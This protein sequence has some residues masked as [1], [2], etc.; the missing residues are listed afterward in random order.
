MELYYRY[1]G[2]N[3]NKLLLGIS[4]FLVVSV[5]YYI[6]DTFDSSQVGEEFHSFIWTTSKWDYEKQSPGDNFHVIIKFDESTVEI[7]NQ[8]AGQEMTAEFYPL[9]LD[10]IESFEK[11]LKKVMK[12]YEIGISIPP[13]TEC[14]IIEGFVEDTKRCLPAVENYEEYQFSIHYKVYQ[15][16]QHHDQLYEIQFV[17][18]FASSKP[19][20][21]T[22]TDVQKYIHTLVENKT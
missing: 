16:S 11:L 14:F 5:G 19:V 17:E 3:K 6:Y 18:G 12:E 10:E 7:R 1:R 8:K 4:L 2:K 15:A 21:E 13:Q 9:S 22:L 20:P